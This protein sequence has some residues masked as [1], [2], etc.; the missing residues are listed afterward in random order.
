MGLVA[1]SSGGTFTPVPAGV[2]VA[3]CYAVYDVGSHYSAMF[4][5]LQHQILVIWEIP[6]ERFEKEVDGQKQ[7]FP[8]V[9]SKYYT[10]SLNEKSNLRKDLESWRGRKFTQQELAGFDVGKL[11]GVG[12]QLNVLHENKNDAVR[13]KISAIMPLP[14][15]TK[16]PPIE[17]PTVRYAIDEH[18]HSL[19]KTCPEWIAKKISESEEWKAI[20]GANGAVQED[21]LSI[22]EDNIPF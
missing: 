17:N 12:C 1:K 14:K 19:P 4:E 15:G 6:G 22:D 11:V 3:N 5:K 8:C 9:I 2:H 10:L 16:A 21:D 7:N 20:G 18:G 13:A